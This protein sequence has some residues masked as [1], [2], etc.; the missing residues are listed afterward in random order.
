MKHT[1][2]QPFK[3]RFVVSLFSAAV[4]GA[5]VWKRLNRELNWTFLKNCLD[6]GSLGQ[7]GGGRRETISSGTTGR[8]SFA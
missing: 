8:I 5:I 1:E 4:E 2:I 6:S 7:G 3:H